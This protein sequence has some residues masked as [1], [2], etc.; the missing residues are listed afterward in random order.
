M[1]TA[2]KILGRAAPAATTWTTAYTVPGGVDSHA[3]VSTLLVANRGALTTFRIAILRTADNAAA[4]PIASIAYYDLPL[5][6]A[7]TWAATI[8][9]TLGPDEKIAVYAG[10]GDVTFQIFGAEVT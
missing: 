2:Y 9:V 4:P 7:E 1:A 10:H 6:T 3:K 5:P 8:G